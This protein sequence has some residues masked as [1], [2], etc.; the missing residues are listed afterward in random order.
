MAVP[1]CACIKMHEACSMPWRCSKLLVM[2]PILMLTIQSCTATSM[3]V[4]QEPYMLVCAGFA[5]L[6]MPQPSG[7]AIGRQLCQSVHDMIANSHANSPTPA[8]PQRKHLQW[9]RLGRLLVAS[10]L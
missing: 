6:P 8:H 9:W 3:H 7:R 2:S 1:P 4:L 5:S 10:L